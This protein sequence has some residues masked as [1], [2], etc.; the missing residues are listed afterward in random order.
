[1]RSET[2][3]G[4]QVYIRHDVR[5]VLRVEKRCENREV[6]SSTY[7]HGLLSKLSFGCSRV[8]LGLKSTSSTVQA[9]ASKICAPL[10]FLKWPYYT[11]NSVKR[12]AIFWCY[13]K[14]RGKSREA[15]SLQNPASCIVFFSSNCAQWPNRKSI[16]SKRR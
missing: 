10:F 7:Q 16:F 14:Q 12:L 2:W 1:M 9:S 11:I 3:K 4:S 6:H 15:S 13:I 5:G 8:P